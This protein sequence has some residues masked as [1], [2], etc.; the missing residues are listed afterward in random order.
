MYLPNELK[1]YIYEYCCSQTKVLL[2]KV[3]K[4]NFYSFNP[5]QN[6]NPGIGRLVKLTI[7]RNGCLLRGYLLRASYPRI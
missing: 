2:N 1:I 7:P 5:L 6:F 3:F 4:W